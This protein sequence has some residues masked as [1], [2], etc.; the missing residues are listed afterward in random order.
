MPSTYMKEY[1]ISR[2]APNECNDH[3]D[4]EVK[5]SE[6]GNEPAYYQDCLALEKSAYE[7]SRVTIN[8]DKMF[9]CCLRQHSALLY[10]LP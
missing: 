7:Q 2:E 4:G 9:E 5:V 8:A 6:T 3:D 10:L 1:L